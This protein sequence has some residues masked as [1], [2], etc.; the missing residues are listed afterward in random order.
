MDKTAES[1]FLRPAFVDEARAQLDALLRSQP[2]IEFIDALL[3]D[4]CGVLRGKRFP[5]GGT[6]HIFEH[7]MQI[8]P[9]IHLMAASGEMVNPFGKG[10]GDGDPDGTAWPI[11]DTIAP[12]WGDGPKRAQILMTLRDDKGAAHPAEPPAALERV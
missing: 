8:P 3:A 4:L 2:D 10:I 9:S 6:S 12:V 11:P 7:G 1:N 5:K